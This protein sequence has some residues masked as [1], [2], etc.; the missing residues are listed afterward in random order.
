MI[1]KLLALSAA[2]VALF[3]SVSA[4]AAA[5]ATNMGTLAENVTT[6]ISQV[7]GLLTAVCYIFGIILVILGILKLKEHVEKPDQ[8]PLKEAFI[9]LVI[10][11]ALFALPLLTEVAFN[12]V[13][14]GSNSGGAVTS[15]VSKV[16]FATN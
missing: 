5:A 2:P 3:A 4:H 12:T 10:G 14:N 11:G 8:T 16:A 6:S 1:K 7:P 9:R 13:D 15:T